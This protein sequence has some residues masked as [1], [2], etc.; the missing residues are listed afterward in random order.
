MRWNWQGLNGG[1][2][3]Q[4]LEKQIIDVMDSVNQSW[5]EA[6]KDAYSEGKKVSSTEM[7]GKYSENV[8]KMIQALREFRERTKK[9][10]KF[11]GVL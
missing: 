9:T 10:K 3:M 6:L 2:K 8:K 5:V 7:M 4:E 11:L 1:N